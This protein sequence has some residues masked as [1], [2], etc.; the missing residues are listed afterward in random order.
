MQY[1]IYTMVLFLAG[2]ALQSAPAVAKKYTGY[3]VVVING[4]YETALFGL[5][6]AIVNRGLT[7][8]HTGHVDKMLE[9]TSKATGGQSPYLGARYLSF[10]SAKLSQAAM[11]ADPDN[12]AACPYVMFAYELKAEPGKARIGYRRPIASEKPAAQKALANIEKL[13]DAIVK[14]AAE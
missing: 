2:A 14:E 9:R 11:Q 10:C 6:N 13:L 5:E 1:L 3:S 12:L 8:D 7:V 4:D